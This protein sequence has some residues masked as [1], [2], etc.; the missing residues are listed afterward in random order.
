[1]AGKPRHVFTDLP[2][3]KTEEGFD[4]SR[5]ARRNVD[6]RSKPRN[7]DGADEDHRKSMGGKARARAFRY[8]GRRFA[9]HYYASYQELVHRASATSK[10]W[11]SHNRNLVA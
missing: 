11:T 2:T 9:E 1:M 7:G 10:E 3:G 8:A 5:C 6:I 4:D